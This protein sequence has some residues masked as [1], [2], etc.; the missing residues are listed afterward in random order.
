MTLRTLV[1]ALLLA[2]PPFAAPAA[3]AQEEEGGILSGS[4]IE[5]LGAIG[6]PEL[7]GVFT[8]VGE[9]NAP[10]AFADLIAR[11]WKAMKRYTRKLAGD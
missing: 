1:V 4:L 7:S 2:A 3:R 6:K 9:R 11:D 5:A 10:R 8:Y